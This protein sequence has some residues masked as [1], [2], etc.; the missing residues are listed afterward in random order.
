MVTFCIMEMTIYTSNL[1][2]Q[3]GTLFVCNCYFGISW[4][5]EVRFVKEEQ[6]KYRKLLWATLT[7]QK[8]S[9]SI[10]FQQQFTCI[11]VHS[12]IT[13]RC[14]LYCVHVV[15][16]K[17]PYCTALPPRKKFFGTLLHNAVHFWRGITL[18]TCLAQQW[19]KEWGIIYIC[20]KF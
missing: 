15:P 13:S 12:V 3:S 16:E 6:K 19:M 11:Y 4:K 14:F 5:G 10:S 17:N 7:T 2:Y 9:C 1:F 18:V 8:M 20:V